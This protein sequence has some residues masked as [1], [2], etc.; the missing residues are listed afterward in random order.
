MTLRH[1]QR[2]ALLFAL[3]LAEAK[4]SFELPIKMI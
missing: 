3:Q 4:L 2:D 1:N